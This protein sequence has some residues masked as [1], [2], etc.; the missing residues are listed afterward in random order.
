MR[1]ALRTQ[2]HTRTAARMRDV[3]PLLKVSF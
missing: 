2:Q 3:R 1:Q